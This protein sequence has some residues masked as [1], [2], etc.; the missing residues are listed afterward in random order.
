M[1]N[2]ENISNPTIKAFVFDIGGVLFLPKNNNG[3]KHLLSSFSAACSHLSSFGIILSVSSLEKIFAI[4]KKSVVGEI[5]KEET[6]RLMSDELKI[7]P[8]EL[9]KL[10]RRLYSDNTNENNRLFDFVL[11]LKS[12]KYKLGILSTQFHLQK[13]I[14]LPSKYN[15]VFDAME[16]SCDSKFKKPDER[17]F[18]AIAEKLKV[19]LEE[20]V[21]V[22]DKQEN[23]DAAKK[24]GM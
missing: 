18:K 13:N 10:F 20:T 15:Q 19:T 12:K 3:G 6:V 14:L 1:T 23:L 22:D 8:G 24:L 16:I 2:D 21:F 5:S 7:S 4:Y 11:Q 17:S 9:E